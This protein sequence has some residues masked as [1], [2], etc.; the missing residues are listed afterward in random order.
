[1]KLRFPLAWLGRAPLT[2]CEQRKAAWGG[3]PRRYRVTAPVETRKQWNRLQ[4]QRR[5]AS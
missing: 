3:I 4:I 2:V 1:M 5:R